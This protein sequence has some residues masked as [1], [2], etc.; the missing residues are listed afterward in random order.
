MVK[1]VSPAFI[2]V[3]IYVFWQTDEHGSIDSTSD[4]E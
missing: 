2:R 4:T 1:F 3:E